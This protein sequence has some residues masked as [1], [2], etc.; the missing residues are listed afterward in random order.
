MGLERARLA[1]YE[2]DCDAAAAWFD[3]DHPPPGSEAEWL[4]QAA[5]GCRR[6]IAATLVDRDEQRAI[7]IRW[8][9]DSDRVLAPWIFDVVAKA[10]DALSRDLGVDWPLPTRIV[11]VRDLWSLSAMT[12]LPYRSA[13]TTGTVAVAKW[14]RVTLLSPRATPHGYPWLDTL[15]H[16]LTHLAVTRATGDKAPLWLQEGVAKRQEVRW[17]QPGPFDGRPPADAVARRGFEVGLGI[18]L[19]RLGPSIAMLPS[20]DAARVAFAEVTSFVEFFAA[21]QPTAALP[22][23]LGALGTGKDTD[24]ALVAASGQDLAWWNRHWRTK[25]A[26]EIGEPLP[27]DSDV[28]SRP[29]RDTRALWNGVRLAQLLAHRGHTA[30]ALE[31][32][33][34]ALGDHGQ[35]AKASRVEVPDDPNLGWLRARLLEEL[36][37]S[38]EAMRVVDDPQMVSASFGPW[39]AERGRLAKS[40]GRDAVAG[41]SFAQALSVDPL[42]EASACGAMAE[43]DAVADG[44]RQRLCDAARAASGPSFDAD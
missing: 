1:L 16:E 37:R 35:A 8:Q 42:D 23:L 7:E 41:Q 19:D 18:P 26:S 22:S 12:A 14:G 10:R 24:E 38:D 2:L 5:D 17:R 6:V 28:G 32:L 30:V 27:L 9:D 39:W 29:D 3:T 36:D 43:S 20:A 34:A 13:Q 11:V 40:F 15:A 25:L 21:E 33:D 44:E 31:R 4:A